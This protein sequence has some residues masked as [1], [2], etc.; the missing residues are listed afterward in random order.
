[1]MSPKKEAFSDLQQLEVK[2]EEEPLLQLQKRER[3]I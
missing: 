3:R 1:M 2:L